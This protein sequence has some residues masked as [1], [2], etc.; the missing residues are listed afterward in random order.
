MRYMLIILLLACVSCRP[1]RENS[2][3]EAERVE[4]E[5]LA[6]AEAERVEEEVVAPID[7]K[8]LLDGSGGTIDEPK[9]VLDAFGGTIKGKDLGEWGGGVT[10]REPD[11]SE[12]QL[13]DDNSRGIFSMPFGLVAVTGFAHMGENRGDIYLISRDI[14][15]RAKA[16]KTLTLSGWPCEVRASD[17]EIML[18]VFQ[19]YETAPNTRRTPNY[20]CYSLQSP[21]DIVKT[22]CP[23]VIPEGCFQ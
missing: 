14:D 7:P 1:S 22:S 16:D 8:H 10:F 21:I 12:H 18:R 4:K 15:G 17:T 6:S 11:G 19:G 2:L 20:N 5:M 23:L 3:A 13:I 9:H